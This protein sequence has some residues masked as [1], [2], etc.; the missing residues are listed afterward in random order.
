MSVLDKLTDEQV[1]SIV[2]LTT[3][4]VS[5]ESIA[6]VVGVSMQE[7]EMCLEAPT[8]KMLLSAA[9]AAEVATELSVDSK[10]DRVESGALNG[11]LNDL[12]SG[13]AV[14][15]PY[16][17]MAL[18]AQ[19]NKARRRHGAVVGKQGV[20]GGGMGGNTNNI[21]VQLNL[22]TV[23]VENMRGRVKEHEEAVRFTELA[24]VSVAERMA[25]AAREKE[26]TE[27][28][29]RFQGDVL[30][31]QQIETVLGVDITKLRSESDEELDPA[32]AMQFEGTGLVATAD[33]D[34]FADGAT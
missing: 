12:E 18:A 22:P 2:V 6:R 4:R 9:G 16:Q 19:A 21:T 15:E 24:G 14:F 33:D 17:L 25:K 13:N 1:R 29:D 31:M 8:V 28:F 3:K 32:F 7:L 23:L 30:N 5:P 26:R 34:E 10:W 11:V 20:L 27:K